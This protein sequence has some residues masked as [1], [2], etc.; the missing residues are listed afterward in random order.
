M[1]PA[2]VPPLVPLP[3][4]D[5]EGPHE[6]PS[7]RALPAIGELVAGRYRIVRPLARGG[8]GAVYVAEHCG[9]ARDVALKFLIVDGPDSARRFVREARAAARLEGEHVVRVLDVGTHGELPFLAMELLVGVDLHAHLAAH[10]PLSIAEAVDYLLQAC[11]ALAEAHAHGIV[12]RDLKPS[13]LFL[14]RSASGGTSLKLLDFGIAKAPISQAWSGGHLTSVV[15]MLGSTPYMSPEH[16]R[17]AG[18]VD[19]RT[20]LWLLGVILYEL[21]T[22]RLPFESTSPMQLGAKIALEPPTPIRAHF[23]DIPEALEA[24][25]ARCLEKDPVARFQSVV[26]LA[27]AL[28][29]FAAHGARASVAR[30][31]RSSIAFAASAEPTAVA[32]PRPSS[33]P[34]QPK[35]FAELV[36]AHRPPERESAARLR[37]AEPSSAK[38]AAAPIS[39]DAPPSGV[40]TSSSTERFRRQHEEL[41]QLGLEIAGK[42]SRKTLPT[43]AANVR[44]LVARFAGKL[45]VHASMENEALYPRLLR[46]PDPAVRARAE[47]LFDE[48]GTIYATFGAYAKRWP[49][50][51][52]IEA[53]NAGF[54]RDTRE[55]LRV[56]AFRMMRENE[57]LYPLVEAAEPTR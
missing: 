54:V 1:V 2:L 14:S 8:M 24:I 57:E 15:E 23:P 39:T 25:V 32:V 18:A 4:S 28:G 30:I 35:A 5:A 19:G 21:L 6:V 20:D 13:N 26:E 50:T 3:V 7:S 51:A 55:V 53:D 10:G 52:S 49:T 44:R 36:R 47:S 40:V 56:L 17:D 34:P 16:L 48:V 11:E 12:H 37:P 9:L 31:E 46:H 45:S 27:R 42:L 29:P 43:D 33:R 22:R 38:I 41:Q